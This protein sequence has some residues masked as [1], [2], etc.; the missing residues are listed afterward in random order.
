MIPTFGVRRFTEYRADGRCFEVYEIQTGKC[1]S[2]P[3][4]R[5][6]LDHYAK[7]LNSKAGAP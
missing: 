7:Q 1:A 4:T 3:G 5:K 6:D 2:F